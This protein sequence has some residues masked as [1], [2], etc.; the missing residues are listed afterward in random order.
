MYAGVSANVYRLTLMTYLEPTFFQS[1]N[2]SLGDDGS[3]Q[4]IYTSSIIGF[5][6]AG[7]TDPS[8]RVQ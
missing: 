3:K 4:P 7:T 8:L 5:R 2:A 1:S 6:W